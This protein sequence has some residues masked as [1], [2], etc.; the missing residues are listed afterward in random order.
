MFILIFFFFFLLLMA[1]MF[2]SEP[3]KNFGTSNK[4]IYSLKGNNEQFVAK[5]DDLRDAIL[6][7]SRLLANCAFEANTEWGKEAS[8]I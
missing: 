5:K 8:I 3:E 1:D 4:F 2:L 7:E 6:E